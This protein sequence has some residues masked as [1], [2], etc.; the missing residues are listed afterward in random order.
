MAVE[1]IQRSNSV[2]EELARLDDQF[3]QLWTH[4]PKSFD[5]CWDYGMGGIRIASEKDGKLEWKL[6]KAQQDA[7]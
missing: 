7:P 5:F 6:K 1:K 2:G 3:S 4:N